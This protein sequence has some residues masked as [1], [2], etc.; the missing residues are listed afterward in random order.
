[1]L[2]LLLLSL[3]SVAGHAAAGAIQLGYPLW[4]DCKG[5]CYVGLEPCNASDIRQQWSYQPLLQNTVQLRSSPNSSYGLCLNVPRYGVAVGDPTW[6]TLCH[7]EH[8]LHANSLWSL[9]N[10]AKASAGAGGHLLNRR[11]KL[12]LGDAMQLAQC[13]GRAAN[14]TYHGSEGTLRSS[15]ARCV[16]VRRGTA[17]PLHP[18]SPPQTASVDLKDP[19]GLVHKTDPRYV[20]FTLDGS[21]NRGWFQRNLSNPLLRFLTKKLTGDTGAILRFGGSGNDYFDYNVPAD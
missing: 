9:Q 10:A 18:P 20:S 2:L 4:D 13:N 17:P 19:R 3:L 21:Y 16:T 11:S 7:P 5:G 12:C 15:G 6:V 8:P 14:F 1:M